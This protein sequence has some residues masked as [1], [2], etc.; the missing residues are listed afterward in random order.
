MHCRRLAFLSSI[1]ALLCACGGGGDGVSSVP[2]PPSSSGNASLTDLRVSQDFAGHIGMA[3]YKLSRDTSGVVR[4]PGPTS[5]SMTVI[6]ETQIRYDARTQSYAL[7]GTL[8]G[9]STFGPG[10]E[11]ASSAASTAYR[12]VAG[13][14]QDDLVLF[15]PGSGN[16]EMALT[17]ASYG[18]WQRI[19][20]N[21]ATLAIDTSFFTYGVETKASEMPKTGSATYQTKIDGQFADNRGVFVLTG[22]SQFEANFATGA[23]NFTMNPK[24]R[25]VVNG[26]LADF[27]RLMLTGRISTPSQSYQGNEFYAETGRTGE[28][29]ANLNGAFYGPGAS[30]MA[31]TFVMGHGTATPGGEGLGAGAVVGKKN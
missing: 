31:A 26:S 30:E 28:Y 20:D 14:Q 24:G 5:S 4:E 1:C 13:N 25:N 8:M 18:A 7:I 15:K 2:A 23:V 22:D 19:A 17:Y 10:Q 3:T 29:T 27:G 9:S 21:G 12:R 11:L 16:P 6:S